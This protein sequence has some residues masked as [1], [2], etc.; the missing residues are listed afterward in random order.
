MATMLERRRFF[1]ELAEL[2]E[3]FDRL[4]ED[5]GH[6]AG[7]T[8]KAAI[9]VVKGEDKLMLRVDM[10]GIKPEDVKIQVEDDILTVSGEHEETDETKDENYIRRERRYGSFSRSL[11]LPP[12]VDPEAITATSKHGVLEVTIPLP[13]EK[14]KKT[15]EIETRAG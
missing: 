5:L 15:V 1:P 9:D 3:R 7:G 2:Q 14:Q 6:G 13:Q 10:P 8:W 12:N 11:A 4:F